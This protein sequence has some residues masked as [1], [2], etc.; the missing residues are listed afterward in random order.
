MVN[1][2]MRKNTSLFAGCQLKIVSKKIFS[3]YDSIAMSLDGE[4]DPKAVGLYQFI[5]DSL[6]VFCC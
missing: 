4:K 3:S 6:F 2:S 5:A 1:Q